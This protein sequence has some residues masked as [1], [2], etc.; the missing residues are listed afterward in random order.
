MNFSMPMINHAKYKKREFTLKNTR[1]LHFLCNIG[2]DA[3]IDN[4]QLQDL[5]KPIRM[6]ETI[7][8]TTFFTF[9]TVFLSFRVDLDPLNESIDANLYDFRKIRRCLA[10][11]RL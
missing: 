3:R 4:R 2:E 10:R 1:N 8:T 11:S 5:V 7:D 6:D 9:I